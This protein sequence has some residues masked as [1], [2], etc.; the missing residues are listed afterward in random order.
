MNRHPDEILNKPGTLKMQYWLR[1][2]FDIKLSLIISIESI[3]GY[4]LFGWPN[5]LLN[6]FFM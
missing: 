2:D 1:F 4:I 6:M 5:G 3:D